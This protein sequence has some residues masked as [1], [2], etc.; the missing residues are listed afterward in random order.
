M[1]YLAAE[2][3]YSHMR[4]RRTGRSGLQLP[5]ITLGLWHNFGADRP[6]ETS[7]AIL[8]RAFD[9][10]VTHF[11]LA[12]NY[13]PPYG[14]AEET[15]GRVFRADFRPYR[16]ELVLSTKAGYDM[17]PG[18]YGEWGSRKYLLA[19]LDQSLGRM[20]LDYVDIFYSHRFDPETPLEETMGA[21]DTAVRSGKALYAGI[22]SY[23]PEMTR[24]AAAILRSLGTPLLIHQ[25]SYSLL[26]RWIEPELLAT[27]DELGVGCIGFSPLAQGMLTDKYL[28]GIPENSRAAENSSLSPDLLTEETLAKIRGLNELAK[29]RGQSL[30]QMSLA[31]TLRDPRMTSTLIGASSIAQLED[32]L[33]ALQRLDFSDDELAEIDGYATD[34]DINLWA[35]SSSN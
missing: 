11:D 4:Y 3:R 32:S 16:D 21:L 5:A 24:E 22:S 20:Q 14:S 2:D 9:L 13:G 33:G 23:S 8:R 6:F 30:A 10:G 1:P 18:P 29:K 12:N 31:W 26:N 34:S 28:N 7:R 15:F 17:W 27:L 19:S 35:R 25:P